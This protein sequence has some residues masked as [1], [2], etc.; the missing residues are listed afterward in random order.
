SATSGP[1]GAYV[2]DH[3]ASWFPFLCVLA[4]LRL[5]VENRRP[6]QRVDDPV[7]AAAQ[8]VPVILHRP[9]VFRSGR[10]LASMPGPRRTCPAGHRVTLWC[11]LSARHWLVPELNAKSPGRKDAKNR[12]GFGLRQRSRRDTEVEPWKEPTHL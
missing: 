11:G 6:R 5:C 7:T 2:V 12:G 1:N 9:L 10:V 8:L 4:P 3:R